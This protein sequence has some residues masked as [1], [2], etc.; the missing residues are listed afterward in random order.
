VPSKDVAEKELLDNVSFQNEYLET[1]KIVLSPESAKFSK[2]VVRTL[3][4]LI[5]SIGTVII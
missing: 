4:V 3:D 2:K 1:L 5:K